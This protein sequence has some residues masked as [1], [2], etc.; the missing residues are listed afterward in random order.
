[1]VKFNLSSNIKKIFVTTF[2]SIIVAISSY[3]VMYITNFKQYEEEVSNKLFMLGK[4]QRDSILRL[5]DEIEDEILFVSNINGIKSMNREE[6]VRISSYLMATK[7]RY[8]TLIAMD[9][10]GKILYGYAEKPEV[11]YENSHFEKAV[12][13]K[14]I[15]SEMAKNPNG[16]AVRM[17][18]PILNYET[19]VV[20]MLFLE[21]GVSEISNILK[22][23]KSEEGMES[24]L[25][26][27]EGVMIT[28]SKF[29]PD[30]IGSVKMN[31]K[32]IK[33][34]IDHSK[35]NRYPDYRGEKVY[36]RYFPIEGTDWSL[37]IESDYNHSKMK[38]EKTK[39]IGQITVAMQGLLVFLV[40]LYCKKRFGVDISEEIENLKGSED[41]S[42][43]VSDIVN[44][45]YADKEE[46]NNDKQNEEKNPPSS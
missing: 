13:T 20:G 5:L 8:K 31:I 18:C 37:L 44:K 26:N 14:E 34:S 3:T 38:Q 11:I 27:K 45:I 21:I 29:L 40:Q 36:G 39:T 9:M 46:E 2:V 6:I 33:I 23:T 19:N 16:Y 1:M 17:Y 24:Y 28:E 42:E 43:V 10:K 4:E 30:A 15:T 32:N 22:S 41:K 35:T 7:P 12:S 25:V